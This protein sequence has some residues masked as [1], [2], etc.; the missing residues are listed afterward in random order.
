M[1]IEKITKKILLYLASLSGTLVICCLLFLTYA[2]KTLNV[3]QDSIV[4]ISKNS[5]TAEVSRNLFS[6]KI[7]DHPTT[8]QIIAK[9]YCKIYKKAIIAGEY[10]LKQGS[11]IVDIIK[12]LTGGKVVQH[13]IMIPQGFTAKQ[14]LERIRGFNNI[15]HFPGIL[16][17]VAEG[18]ILP[19]TYFYTYGTTDLD[20]IKRMQQAM[21][22]FLLSE[23]ARRDKAIDE[24]I[25]SPEDALILA[26][27]IE[28]ET[29]L[30]REKPLIAGVY[31]NRL[32]KDMKLQ[33]DPTVIYGLRLHETDWNGRVL[34]SH[35]KSN[36]E[37]NTYIN[38]GLPPTPIC[39]PGKASIT[40][41]LHPQWTKK[42][43]FV[44]EEN[45]RHIFASDFNQHKKNIK[46]VRNQD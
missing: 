4:L 32:K 12:I 33:A 16:G 20:L 41:V 9:L 14:V 2:F 25:T 44:V 28:K 6:N 34:Y 22:D 13:R 42:L 24:F 45:G 27:I 37:Y 19:E 18:S 36:S 23:W 38:K 21:E 1:Q 17:E 11:G 39:N 7:L 15:T 29:Y 3:K 8:F 26:S 35:L 43:F 46:L 10:S 40:A 5:T 30:D 31:I